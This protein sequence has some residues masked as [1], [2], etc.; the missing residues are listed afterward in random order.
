VRTVPSS[1][2][3]LLLPSMQSRLGHLAT[4]AKVDATVLI[5]GETGTGKSI[6]ARALHD[7]SERHNRPF[8][9]CDCAALSTQLIESEL[10][11]HEKGAFTGAHSRRIGRFEFAHGGTLFLDEIAEMPLETQVKLLGAIQDR[12]FYRVGGTRPVAVDIRIIAAS[13]RDLQ[14]EVKAGRLR[15]D[16][17][18][19]LNVVAIGLPPLRERLEDLE[20]LAHHF[21]Q[22]YGRKLRRNV[23]S[24]SPAALATMRSYSWPGNIR[25]LENVIE[26]ALLIDDSPVLGIGGELLDHAS[27]ETIAPASQLE[28]RPTLT[29]AEMET[30]YIQEVLDATSWR[31]SGP[32]GAARLLG[33]HPNTLRSRMERLRISRPQ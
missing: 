28:K 8:V 2:T 16:L 25:E 12:Q 11:G 30:R 23:N 13:N 31:I 14:E 18:Y 26:R 9:K 4:I 1:Y 10:F 19:R 32:G 22:I 6:L 3:L 7:W 24:L 33:L 29:L 5:T 27:K 21:I 20:P 17:F 15:Q